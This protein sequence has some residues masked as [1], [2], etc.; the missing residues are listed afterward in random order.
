MSGLREVLALT[1]TGASVEAVA[2]TL[3]MRPEAVS[4][5]LDHAERLGLAEPVSCT[6]CVPGGRP[7][8]CAGCPIAA[9]GVSP[10]TL[11]GPP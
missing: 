5:V 2:R 7:R 4:A 11:P 10:R 8:G 6:S 1:G 9:A 3:G